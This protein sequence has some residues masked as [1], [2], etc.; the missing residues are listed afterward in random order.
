MGVNGD[1]RTYTKKKRTDGKIRDK[2]MHR[3][4]MC[5]RKIKNTKICVK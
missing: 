4:K 2:N 1:I 5:E 3:Q